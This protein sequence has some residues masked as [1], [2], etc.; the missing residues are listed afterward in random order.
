MIS[1]FVKK[2]V[3][4]AGSGFK[5]PKTSFLVKIN[6]VISLGGIFVACWQLIPFIPIKANTYHGMVRGR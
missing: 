2:M 3:T 6:A 5:P 1:Y 4:G